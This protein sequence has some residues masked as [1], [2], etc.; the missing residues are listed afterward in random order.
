MGIIVF[1]ISDKN[2]KK[3]GWMQAPAVGENWLT[4][5]IL[6]YMYYAAFFVSRNLAFVKMILL[7]KMK[8]P[9]DAQVCD[10]Q[11][12]FCKDSSCTDQIAT[13]HI[14]IEQSIEW[15]LSL[16]INFVDYEKGFDSFDSVDRE[17]SPTSRH[18]VRCQDQC[19]QHQPNHAE[20]WSIGR[21]LD[22]DIKTMSMTW[23]Q[24]ERRA[25]DRDAW[26][27]LVDG[28]CPRRGS[29]LWWSLYSVSQYHNVNDQVITW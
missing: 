8:D 7:N 17:V 26:R 19:S 27:L 3:I 28:L 18:P 21:V 23:S 1:T 25:Q 15:N 13:M 11:A 6:C 9:I 29:R 16:Y 20:W 12:S 24:L 14:I 2:K 5:R 4:N 10:E 22:P